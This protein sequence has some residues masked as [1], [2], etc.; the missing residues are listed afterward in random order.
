I[1]YVVFGGSVLGIFAGIYYWF[2]KMFGRMMNA[3]LGKLHFWLTIIFFNGTFFPMHILGVGGHM[4]RIAN[5]TYYEFL[6]PLQHWNVFISVSA[7]LLGS[8]QIFFVINFLMS[9]ASGRRA[10]ENPW[11]ANTLE[12]C[13]SP[14]PG[15]HGNFPGALPVVYRG[16]YEYSSPEVEEDWLP[17][18][19]K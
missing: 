10:A 14:T 1:H 9:L 5:P 7:F 8:S 16:P 6:A 3:P 15:I 18:N 17:Q 4:R 13:A 11:N 12:W 19:R 2:P